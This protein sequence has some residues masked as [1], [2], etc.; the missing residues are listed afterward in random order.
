[1]ARLE[2]AHLHRYSSD[3]V[4]LPVTLALGGQ[5]SHLVASLDTGS[6]HCMFERLHADVL[7]LNVEDGV[8]RVFSTATGNLEAY[9]HLVHITTFG[10]ELES[11]VYFFANPAITRNLLGR[12][13]WLNRV[14]LGIVDYDRELYLSSYDS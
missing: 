11:M 14:R 12:V 3:A 2:F 9:G 13:G 4:T 5:I 8:R 1:M 10:I 6:S 7:R